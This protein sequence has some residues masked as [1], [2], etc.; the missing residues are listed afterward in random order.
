MKAG[1]GDGVAGGGSI[2]MYMH[3]CPQKKLSLKGLLKLFLSQPA[4]SKG[5][6]RNTSSKKG[7]C[8]PQPTVFANDG[9]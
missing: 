9:R 5:K 7:C 6:S 2:A 8:G 1:K 4:S 3:H